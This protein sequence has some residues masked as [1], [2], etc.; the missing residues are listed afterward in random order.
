LK[1]L[2][3]RWNVNT[4]SAVPVYI[5]IE[6]IVQFALANGKAAADD[7]LPSV[8][9]LSEAV[10]VNANTIAKAYRDLEVMGYLYTRRGMGVYIHKAGPGIAKKK[11]AVYI[12]ERLGEVAR[13]AAACGLKVDP[14][15]VQIRQEFKSKKPVYS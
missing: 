4:K 1:R 9:E 3:L 15:C 13:E 5:Q 7:Q 12:Q 6:R 8:R 11:M 10:K 2:D 14:M